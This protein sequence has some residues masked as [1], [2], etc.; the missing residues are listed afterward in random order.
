MQ[1]KTSL[2]A[3][4]STTVRSIKM[5]A[6][7]WWLSALA[8]LSPE[9][10]GRTALRLFGTPPPPRPVARG[11]EP[12]LARARRFSVEI[13]DATVQGYVWGAGPTAYL[14]HG[15]GGRASQ[16]TA[17]VEPLLL[18]AMALIVGFLLLAIYYPLLQVYASS[19]GM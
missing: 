14:V 16:L 9:R 19:K 4:N 1:N 10:A 13:E 17:L 3:Q 5:V 7:G 8:R 6:G 18:V 2:S 11:A 12:V 15:W